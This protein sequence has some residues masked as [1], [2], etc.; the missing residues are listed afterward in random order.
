MWSRQLGHEVTAYRVAIVAVD[1]D[2]Y[3]AITRWIE[4][5]SAHDDADRQELAAEQAITN[6]RAA[7]IDAA[8]AL[9][10]ADARC[11]AAERPDSDATAEDGIAAR[12]VRAE[13]QRRYDEADAD[14]LSE[15]TVQRIF[16]EDSERES[17]R[18]QA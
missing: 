18:A 3:P 17:S 12:A 8:N 4:A 13:A 14:F 16:R 15:I 9:A 10:D 5:K 1:P 6:L 2:R 7:R 11:R